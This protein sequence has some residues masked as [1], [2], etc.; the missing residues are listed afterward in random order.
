LAHDDLNGSTHAA[1][2]QRPMIVVGDTPYGKISAP[3]SLQSR[4]NLPVILRQSDPDFANLILIF[5][6]ITI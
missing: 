1:S 4:S 2:Q 6:F 3:I 5:V